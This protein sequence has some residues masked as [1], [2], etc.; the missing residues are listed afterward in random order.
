MLKLTLDEGL[1]SSMPVG[2]Y[3]YQ[4]N[5]M[6]EGQKAFITKK[7]GSVLDPRWEL[8]RQ[9]D[10]VSTDWTGD[11]KTADEALA[12]LQREVQWA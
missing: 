5:G 7:A 1:R 9:K 11:Y 8:R 2:I 10:D 6:P 3:Q 12:V 4:V